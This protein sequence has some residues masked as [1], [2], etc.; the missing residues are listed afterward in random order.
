MFSIIIGMFIN[1]S[2]GHVLV[3]EFDWLAIGLLTLMSFF[4]WTA[5]VG[6]TKALSLDK[7]GRVAALNYLQVVMAWIF[8]VTCFGAVVKWTDMVGTVFIIG[9]TFF[10][11][12]NKFRTASK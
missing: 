9:F 6:V 7:A 11:A 12:L 10:G 8:D 3:Q 5:Q 4:G 2:F 1:V